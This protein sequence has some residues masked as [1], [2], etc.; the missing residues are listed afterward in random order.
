M[1]GDLIRITLLVCFLVDASGFMDSMKYRVFRFVKGRNAPYAEFGLKPF[2]CS[3]RMTWW[4]GLGYLWYTGQLT[5]D[6]V[7]RG[8]VAAHLAEVVSFGMNAVKEVLGTVI[9]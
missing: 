5:L 9:S 7:V 2:D 3:L 4:A 1:S 8:A 6:G